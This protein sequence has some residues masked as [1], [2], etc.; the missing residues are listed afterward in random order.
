MSRIKTLFL[1]ASRLH[2]FDICEDSWPNE[3]V[4]SCSRS[5]LSLQNSQNFY[6]E[7]NRL[8]LKKVI[9]W[10]CI[11]GIF[12]PEFLELLAVFSCLVWHLENGLA[13]N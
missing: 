13:H 4:T 5:Q 3:K 2:L 11:A 7:G 9:V 6:F 1:P 12:F 10:L 8:S